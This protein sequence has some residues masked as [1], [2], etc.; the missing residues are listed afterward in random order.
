MTD[1][2][3]DP[4]G[5]E[6]LD[7]FWDSVVRGTPDAPGDLD[8]ATRSGVRPFHALPDVPGPAPSFVARLE[9]ELMS[10]HVARTTTTPSPVR[11]ASPAAPVRPW[12]GRRAPSASPA[13][14]P[15]WLRVVEFAAVAAL[16]LATVAG[17]LVGRALLPGRDADDHVAAPAVA[18]ASPGPAVAEGA[19]MLGGNAART[20]EVKGPGP[21]TDPEVRWRSTIA[22]DEGGECWSSPIVAGG[23]VYSSCVVTEDH[24]GKRLQSQ[25]LLLAL[26]AATGEERWR[27]VGTHLATEPGLDT[28]HLSEPAVADGLLFVGVTGYRRLDEARVGVDQEP[29]AVGAI[30][31]LDALTGRERWRVRTAGDGAAA[32]AVVDGAVYLASESGTVTVVDAVN[33]AP[34]WQRTVATTDNADGRGWLGTPAVA[35]GLVLVSDHLRVLHALDAGSGE[36]RWRFEAG[37]EMVGDPVV[38]GDTVYVA[39]FDP[40]RG[41]GEPGRLNALDTATGGVRW[42]H[43]ADGVGF[44]TPVVGGGLVFLPGAGDDGSRVIALDAATG[45]ERWSFGADGWIGHSLVLAAGVIYFT[46]FEDGV[47]G[48]RSVLGIDLSSIGRSRNLY[49][50]EVA[51]GRRLWRTEPPVDPMGGLGVGSGMVYLTAGGEGVLA[52]GTEE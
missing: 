29:E 12:R 18:N 37:G 30:V 16:I 3:D 14:R 6:A 24:D 49:A 43:A 28:V 32:P 36:E 38:D 33:G 13:R 51:T 22:A 35:G 48:P 21:T 46:S 47:F 1:N 10:E 27:A 50:I 31:A 25:S 7:R 26:D 39:S 17:A 8:P 45:A 41:G 15:V 42:S 9:E 11:L 34:R 4:R 20:G 44:V 52:W 23:L 19:A 2:R 5:V 40:E